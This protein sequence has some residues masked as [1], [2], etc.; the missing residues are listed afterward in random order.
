MWFRH[1][2]RRRQEPPAP[3]VLAPLDR[4]SELVERVVVLLDQAPAPAPP[5][6]PETEPEPEPAPT[7][8]LEPPQSASEGHVLLVGDAAGYRLLERE[9]SPPGRGDVLEV[10]EAR[11]RVIR[12]GPSPFPADARRCAF[13]EQERPE[14]ARTPD[15]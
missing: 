15:A 9:G 8:A 10:G 6:A 4:L 3:L 14:A 5:A 7:A 13:V 11:L 12:L 1:W 2:R